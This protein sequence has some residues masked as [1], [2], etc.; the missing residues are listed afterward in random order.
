[1]FQFVDKCL[2]HYLMSDS[3]SR[4]SYGISYFKQYSAHSMQFCWLQLLIQTPMNVGISNLV[5]Y[6]ISWLSKLS[7][8]FSAELRQVKKETYL[9]FS[10]DEG[11]S[12]TSLLTAGILPVI[13]LGGDLRFS[14]FSHFFLH[15]RKNGCISNFTNDEDWSITLGLPMQRE[16][17]CVK[18]DCPTLLPP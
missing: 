8:F 17:Q 5:C 7:Y 18:Q 10:D 3:G 9:N 13:N 2:S 16:P 4:A 15:W 14:E 11:W 12:K 6:F 1:M